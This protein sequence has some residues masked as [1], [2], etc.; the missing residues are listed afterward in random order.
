MYRIIIILLLSCLV[1]AAHHDND[2][3]HRVNEARY[4]DLLEDPFN[5]RFISIFFHPGA[6]HGGYIFTDEEKKEI[7]WSQNQEIKAFPVLLEILKR[8]PNP[9]KDDSGDIWNSLVFKKSVLTWVR[10]FSEGDS[11]PFVEEIRR[12]L[13]E[14]LDRQIVIHDSHTGFIR[15]ALDLLAR[16]GDESDITLI[17]SFLEDANSNN[18]H[19]A[20]KSLKKLKDRLAKEKETSEIRNHRK[21]RRDPIDA[22]NKINN[23]SVSSNSSEPAS[24]TE[25]GGESLWSKWLIML[26]VFLVLSGVF[27]WL[28]A[29]SRI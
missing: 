28:K 4:K 1:L 10:V 18:K 6:N 14:W 7:T 13:P 20:K 12:Q 16:E 5:K 27:I 25:I 9:N 26:T 29:K 23:S 19:N 15:A 21:K 3:Q 17:E 24:T 2:T 8:E 11:R 22:D